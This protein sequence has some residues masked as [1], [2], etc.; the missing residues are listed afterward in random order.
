MRCSCV[1]VQGQLCV[2]SLYPSDLCLVSNGYTL[3]MLAA[4]N[5]QEVVLRALL[6]K[7]E[8]PLDFR[9][10]QVCVRVHACMHACEHVWM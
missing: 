10:M 2:E 5:N 7:G 4:M 6:G 9:Q 3:L 1:L 8:C